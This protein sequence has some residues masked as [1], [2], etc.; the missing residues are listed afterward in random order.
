[1]GLAPVNRGAGQRLGFIP[2]GAGS[3]AEQGDGV[4]VIVG[5]ALALLKQLAEAGSTDYVR[6]QNIKRGKARIG[7][8]EIEILGRVFP[9]FRWWLLTGEV[10]PGIGQTS[11]DYDEANR[12][13]ANPN[14]G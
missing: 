1:M 2:A 8:N 10:Q 7:A 6:W 12:N 4:G 14:A 11:P 3:Q 13:L 5:G 9:D